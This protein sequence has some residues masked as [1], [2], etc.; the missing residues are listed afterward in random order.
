MT[1]LTLCLTVLR[2]QFV[3]TSVLLAALCATALPAVPC[4]RDAEMVLE[5]VNAARSLGAVCGNRGAFGEAPPLAWQERLLTMA[6]QH[7][8]YL[9]SIAQLRHTGPQGETVGP[10]AQ[11][12]GYRYQRVGENLA[13]GQRDLPQALREWTA[14]E[15]HCAALYNPVYTEMALACMPAR[16]GRPL[17]VLVLGRPLEAVAAFNPRQEARLEPRAESLLANQQH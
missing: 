9:V 3:R 13:H 17:W 11:Q 6:Q 7:A 12:V 5:Q 8:S 2:P 10:R 1:E 14:S 16:D 4:P 15:S